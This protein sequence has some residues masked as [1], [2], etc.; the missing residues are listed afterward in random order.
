VAELQPSPSQLRQ[1]DGHTGRASDGHARFRIDGSIELQC[2]CCDVIDRVESAVRRWRGWWGRGE[3]TARL[4]HLPVA[5][6]ADATPGLLVVQIDGLSR[7]VLRR[8]LAEGRMPFTRHL[9]DVE[10]ARLEPVYSGIPSTTPAVQGELFYGVPLAVPAFSFVDHASG[11]VFRMYERH[12]VRE[13]ERRLQE[14]SSGSLLEGG[15][16]Y[17]NVFTGGA[18]DA[19]F[20]MAS[21]GWGDLFHSRHPAALL[22]V[23]AN[24]AVDVLRALIW[25]V[26]EVA[27]ASA[28]CVSAW[29]EGGDVRSE[30]K[31]VQTRVGIGVLLR[32]LTAMAALVDLGRGVRVVHVNLL[33]YDEYAH[34]RGPAAPLAMKALTDAD[35]IIARLT[36]AA[37]RARHRNYDIWLMSDHGQEETTSY[38]DLNG[39]AVEDAIAEIFAQAGIGEAVRTAVDREPAG[40]ARVREAGREQAHG[41]QHQRVRALG[42]HLVGWLVP[43]LDITTRV[44][45]D[46]E[47]VVTAQGPLG[48]VYPPRQLTDEEIERLGPRLAA[49]AAVPLVLAAGSTT[50]APVRAWTSTRSYALPAEAAELLGTGHPNLSEVAADLVA[51]VAHPD[52]GAFVISGWRSPEGRAGPSISFAREHGAHSGP[53]ADET[54][55]FAIVP[56]DT[57]LPDHEGALRPAHLRAAGLQLLHRVPPARFRGVSRYGRDDHPNPAPPALRVMTYNVHS[58]L[59]LDGKRSTER[60]ARVIARHDPDVVALQELDAGRVR[61][62]L[63]DQAVEIA[64]HLEM[65]VAF[66]PTI[67]VGEERFGDA[68]LSRAPIRIVRAEALPA[69]AGRPR[70]EPRG[71]LWV[72]VERDGHPVQVINTHLSLHWR[73]RRLQVDALLGPDWLGHPDA[74]DVVLCGDL[75]ALS[76]FPECRALARL[77]TDV[78]ADRSTGRARPTWAGRFPLARIDHVYVDATWRVL[79][80]TVPDHHLARVASDHRPLVVDLDHSSRGRDGPTREG[81]G[82][83]Q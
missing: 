77:L 6:D 82:A 29:R 46:G 65:L 70:L 21:L 33:G 51:L 44:R 34:R 59:G 16:S 17:G 75:N 10:H 64:R 38:A 41:I 49:Q 60:I 62:G 39:R 25:I 48:H 68:V 15:A 2:W 58:C 55:A 79:D 67:S 61:S 80:V 24:Q 8:A 63:V 78:Q 83:V 56:A 14:R 47:L 45:A 27:S 76:W 54:D 36:R 72:E 42:E 1:N 32:E 73:E 37:R 74:Q 13:V 31:F 66:H 19:R 28:G 7:S 9:L 26:L 22:A 57:P 52:A 53:G 5:D 43:G 18:A 30:L 12:A 23:A 3:W 11:R 35:R 4:L 71:A 50:G 40:H 69:L 20:C 81:S